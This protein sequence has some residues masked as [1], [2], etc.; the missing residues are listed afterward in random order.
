[1]AKSQAGIRAAGIAAIGTLGSSPVFFTPLGLRQK[2]NIVVSDHNNPENYRGQKLR[3]QMNFKADLST[4]QGT[5]SV[6]DLEL[7]Y[8]YLNFVMMGGCDAQF[9]LMEGTKSDNRFTGDVLNF[10]GDDFLG[11]DL[12][13]N[14]TPKGRDIKLAFEAAVPYHRGEAII[15][16]GKTNQQVTNF[17]EGGALGNAG[18]KYG[19]FASPELLSVQ[20][21]AGSSLFEKR[22]IKDFK[23]QV[24]TPSEKSDIDNRSIAH[25]AEVIF[26]ITAVNAG[27]VNDKLPSLLAKPNEV[28]LASSFGVGAS[29]TEGLTFNQGVLSLVKEFTFG[30]DNRLSKLT[31]NGMIPLKDFVNGLSTYATGSC[32]IGL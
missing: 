18:I 9:I 22:D 17:N 15:L 31:F 7:L 20:A 28:Q 12:D 4:Y 8:T 27:I 23:F 29:G 19:N 1:M 13:F 2:G 6:S 16:A 5:G 3:N 24:K 26:E 10:T 21:P 25:F 32:T 11:I 30:D 14:L